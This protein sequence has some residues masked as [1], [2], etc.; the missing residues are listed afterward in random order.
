VLII[1]R[2]FVVFRCLLVCL[3]VESITQLSGGECLP[4]Y[5]RAISVAAYNDATSYK[6]LARY[7]YYY[8]QHCSPDVIGLHPHHLAH[9][10]Q[11]PTLMHPHDAPASRVV[12]H[13]HAGE[14]GDETTGRAGDGYGEAAV[15]AGTALR[16]YAKS[17]STA[18]PGIAT[19]NGCRPMTTPV[20]NWTP[21]D[22]G[23]LAL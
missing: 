23:Q 15:T 14:N 12:Y 1:C 9:Q 6:D 5:G 11:Q 19:V 7:Y 16:Y 2:S 17:P 22:H 18:V 20:A 4:G 21:A 3:S 8:P 13:P 10:P